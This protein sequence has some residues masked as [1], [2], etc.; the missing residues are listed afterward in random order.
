VSLFHKVKVHTAVFFWYRSP[1]C[2]R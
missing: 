2:A 1:G